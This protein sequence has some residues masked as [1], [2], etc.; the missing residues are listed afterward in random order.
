M[1]HD[2]RQPTTENP[3]TNN[4]EHRPNGADGDRRHRQHWPL[5]LLCT[6]LH[7]VGL[8][9]I[10]ATLFS[11][12]GDVWWFFELFSHFRVQYVVG[13]IACLPLLL[14]A[15]QFRLG[16]VVGVALLL[17]LSTVAPI[18]FPTG[19]TP[20]DGEWNRVLFANVLSANQQKDRLL[21][22]VH[23]E[24][25]DF[26]VLQEVTE[27]WMTG[28]KPLASRYPH[29]LAEPRDDNFGIAL[30]SKKPWRT[31]DVVYG[32]GID[33]PMIE[34]RFAG[35]GQVPF[36]LFSMHPVPPIGEAMAKL[37]NRHMQALAGH[38]REWHQPV[39]LVGDLNTTP[40]SPR[41]RAFQDASG[42]TGTIRGNGWQPTWPTGFAPL[43]IPLD[44]CFHSKTI[45]IGAKRVGPDIGSDH[46]P[47]IIDFRVSF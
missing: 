10:A 45:I 41:Y 2:S 30:L 16:T 29:V 28:L 20:D 5:V 40:W 33:L 34:A 8:V 31:A 36:T 6:I 42:L 38:L 37:R 25:P 46:F 4:T 47:L 15:K 26:I 7:R 3:T 9:L 44:H 12:A 32:D 24:D 1:E 21:E 39:L 35:E 14:I 22:L 11:F 17:N 13:L 43:Y 18:F 19:A 27:A 23:K